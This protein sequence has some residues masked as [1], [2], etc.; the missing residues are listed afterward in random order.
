MLPLI[1]IKVLWISSST[2]SSVL[3]LRGLPTV[4][5]FRVYIL[6]DCITHL[7]SSF[8]CQRRHL[9]H[10]RFPV[11]MLS[12]LSSALLLAVSSLAVVA[13]GQDLTASLD[14]GTFQGTYNSQYNLSYWRKIP[15]AAPPVGEN[16]FRAPQPPAPITNGTY[17]SNQS[18]DY[19]PQRTVYTS[20]LSH[21]PN[22]SFSKHSLT[23]F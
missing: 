5:K 1:V 21:P 7:L 20:P 2:L 4:T 8:L 6:K 13:Q 23:I 22:A 15:F 19:C 18:F 10:L 3:E 16:R 17:D 14:Y 12:S 9:F 11:N